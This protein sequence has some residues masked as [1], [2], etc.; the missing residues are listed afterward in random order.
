MTKRESRPADRAPRTGRVEL[1]CGCM[2][3]GKTEELLRRA[4]AV[5]PNEIVL[6]KHAR[7]DRYS[8]TD[9]VTHRHDRHRAVIVQQAGEIVEHLTSEADFVGIDEGHFFDAA[10]ADVCTRLAERGCTVVVTA[11]D[12]DS[13][14]RPFA[15]VNE[16]RTRADSV[17]IRHAPCACCGRP[18]DHTQ[19]TTPIVEGNLVG[20]PEAF[21]PRCLSCWSPPPEDPI[22]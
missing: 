15:T 12:L 4:R 17:L 13:W 9:V 14:G 5:A 6:V 7:D 11:L 20:G 10:L 19:R 2:F 8:T 18:A 1:V 22:D 21:E 3:S 16:L